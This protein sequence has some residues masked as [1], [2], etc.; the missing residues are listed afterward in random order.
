MLKVSVNEVFMHYFQNMPSVYGSFAPKLSLGLRSWTLLGDIRHP[1]LLICLP[2]EKIMR[3][4]MFV[5]C[6]GKYS[7][8]RIGRTTV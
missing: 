2:L 5:I 4:P 6:V 1:D 8:V 7:R 3:A